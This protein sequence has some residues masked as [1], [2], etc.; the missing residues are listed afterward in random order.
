MARAY[1]IGD[2]AREAGVTA[3]ALRYYEQQ[4]L[5]PKSVRSASGARMFSEDT[6]GRVRF[7]KQAQSAGLT[8]RDIQV[9]VGSRSSNSACR[10]IR[11]ILAARID[12]I[13]VRL[14]ELQTFRHSLS[15]HLEACDRAIADSNGCGC[16][17][18]DAIERAKEGG[19]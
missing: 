15:A 4:K 2:V 3:E 19:K 8:L 1:R 5:L 17:T 6:V 10:K 16:P 9:L 11:A 18:I 12:E 7:I 14:G 13:D